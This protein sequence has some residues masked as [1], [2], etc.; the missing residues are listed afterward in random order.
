MMTADDLREIHLF[1]GGQATLEG[2]FSPPLHPLPN[3]TVVDY[4]IQFLSSISHRVSHPPFCTCNI[5]LPSYTYPEYIIHF[6]TLQ[7]RSQVII[8]GGL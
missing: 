4:V 8:E 3:A 2:K 5:T 7:S 6:T 1:Q